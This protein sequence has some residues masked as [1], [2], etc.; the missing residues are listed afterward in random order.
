MDEPRVRNKELGVELVQALKSMP[1]VLRESLQGIGRPDDSAQANDKLNAIA[2]F[3]FEQSLPVIKDSDY[4]F[5]R[6]VREFQS[7][8]DCHSFGRRG[9]VLMTNLPSS[10]IP[11]RA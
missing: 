11:S 1:E 7:I 5:E 2:G 9:S 6:H 4:D 10:G 8:L 3:K